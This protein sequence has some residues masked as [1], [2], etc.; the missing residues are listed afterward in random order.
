MLTR[1]SVKT[2][3]ESQEGLSFTEFTYQ[4]Q[5]YKLYDCHCYP[6]KPFLSL[7]CSKPMT[8]YTCTMNTIAQFKLVAQISWE[9]FML[10]MI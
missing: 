6:Y 3:M 7:R 4:V 1:K 2:R 5:N 9:T 8:G 10:V